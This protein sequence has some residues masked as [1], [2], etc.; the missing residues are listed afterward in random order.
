MPISE[1]LLQEIKQ[2]IFIGNFLD[3]SEQALKDEDVIKLAEV[4]KNN[5]KIEKINLSY[6]DI[7]DN[8]VKAISEVDTINELDFHN[9]LD[10]YG[11]CYNHITYVG[12]K[13]LANSSLKK[14]NIDGNL[15][16]DD[17]IKFLSS[18]KTIVNL[19][20][21]DCGVSAEG[22]AA[23]FKDNTALIKLNLKANNIEDNGLSTIASNHTLRELDL[24]DCKIT[25]VGAKFIEDND[26]LSRLQLSGNKISRGFCFLAKHSSL[27]FLGLNRCEISDSDLVGSNIN[28]TLKELSLRYNKITSKGIEVLSTNFTLTSL[29]LGNNDI[30]FDEK[31]LMGL[32]SMKSLTVFTGEDNKVNDSIRQTIEELC[33]PSSVKLLDLSI[34]KGTQDTVFITYS[35]REN[36]KTNKRK[37][38]KLADLQKVKDK[39]L[40]ITNQDPNASKKQNTGYTP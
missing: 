37:A 17:G 23:L 13:A 7:G 8:G 35:F 32:L 22:A 38:A 9:G 19:S 34:H 26:S 33:K 6:N 14:L 12:A 20:A 15:I 36:S 11:E 24:S 28:N 40:N 4:L 39:L 18:N 10:G 21:E 3:L 29:H 5:P 27:E 1:K 16:G 25:P 2:K 31:T 30:Y